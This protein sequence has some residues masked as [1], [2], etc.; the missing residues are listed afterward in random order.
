MGTF[1][2]LIAWQKS[3][4]LVDSVYIAVR[5]FPKSEMF[6]LTQQMKKCASSIPSNIAEGRGRYTNPDQ[7]HFYRQARGS[8]YEL[9]T[10][11]EIARRQHLMFDDVASDLT[12]RANEVGRLINGLLNSL[13]PKA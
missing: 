9:Q 2:N 1:R 10:Q 6:A 13:R 11:I 3:M 7:Q 8:I 4:D 12:D 5:D